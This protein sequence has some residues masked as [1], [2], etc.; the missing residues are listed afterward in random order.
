[1]GIAPAEV[2]VQTAAAQ[3]VARERAIL[4]NVHFRVGL[5]GV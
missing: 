5:C 2:A 4:L 3:L 1:M